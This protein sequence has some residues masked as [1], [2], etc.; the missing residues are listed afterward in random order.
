M[1]STAPIGTASR[2]QLESPRLE[3]GQRSALVNAVARLVDAKQSADILSTG[4]AAA[5]LDPA[6]NPAGMGGI[7]SF[8]FLRQAIPFLSMDGLSS[9]GPVPVDS[10]FGES[11]RWRP[12]DVPVGDV[13]RLLAYLTDPARAGEGD[14]DRAE[15][16]AWPDL[17][18]YVAH[19]GKNR[20]A[21]LR[22]HGVSTMPAGIVSVAYPTAD[23]IRRYQVHDGNADQVWAVLDDRFAQRLPLY[24]LGAGLLDAYGIAP[25]ASWPRTLPRP[26]TVRDAIYGSV[27]YGSHRGKVREWGV[28]VDLAM[29]IPAPPVKP[30]AR[31]QSAL[32][33]LG[34]QLRYGVLAGWGV[35]SLVSGII[36]ANLPSGMIA[37]AAWLTYGVGIGGL[38]LLTLPLFR[39]T[40]D[41]R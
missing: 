38:L 8:H 27:P 18:I 41:R 5:L 39:A 29:D 37:S 13:P 11:W 26:E 12:E 21:L 20:V 14:R 35:G 19:E 24:R 6:I 33:L 17:G 7:D 30:V 28:C 34:A 36:A 9:K 22:A 10:L 16:F 2:P 3:S 23:R 25:L 4:H 40:V 31:F 15:V 32:D 1:S